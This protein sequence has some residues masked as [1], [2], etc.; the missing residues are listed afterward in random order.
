MPRFFTPHDRFHLHA[1]AG[2]LM[3][4]HSVVS[5]YY[6]FTQ[7]GLLY[8]RDATFIEAFVFPTLVYGFLAL[9]SFQFKV[10]S[11]I[12]GSAIKSDLTSGT[13]RFMLRHTA[14][15]WTIVRC[16][17]WYPQPLKSLDVLFALVFVSTL[18]R[19]PVQ[20]TSD[21]W[22]DVLNSTWF[23][24]CMVFYLALALILSG[25]LDT[26]VA[27]RYG[28]VDGLYTTLILAQDSTAIFAFL[29]T[30][31]R[32]GKIS[33]DTKVRLQVLVL[34][35]T[36]IPTFATVYFHPTLLTT[37]LLYISTLNYRPMY[38]IP[39]LMLSLI[40]I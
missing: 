34:W 40:H 19:Y 38:L 5:G 10:P 24:D 25:E 30:L 29:S 33:S 39:W 13:R 3:L 11:A 14:V 12:S 9:S 21:N 4:L 28:P 31:A 35:Y 16:C 2:S 6:V 7:A 23:L 27:L 8:I 36:M 17:T 1:M 15:G 26:L 32:K 18:W 20:K 22:V 37:D